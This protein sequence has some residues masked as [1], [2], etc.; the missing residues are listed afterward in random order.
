[1]GIAGILEERRASCWVGP[2]PADSS[3]PTSAGPP[4]WGGLFAWLVVLEFVKDSITQVLFA[5]WGPDIKFSN[6]CPRFY[7]N[8]YM[9]K[10]KSLYYRRQGFEGRDTKRLVGF[11]KVY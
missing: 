10:L 2:R 11:V 7:H 1:M 5:V 9:G 4:N 3:S 8:M 6:I